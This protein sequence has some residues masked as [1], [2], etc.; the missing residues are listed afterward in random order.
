ML[1][2]VVRWSALICH[3]HLSLLL[4]LLLGM[5]V[6]TTK[7]I[8]G[9]LA[10]EI[11]R[12]R[13]VLSCPR[14]GTLVINIDHFPVHIGLLLLLLRMVFVLRL[15]RILLL[16]LMQMLIMLMLLLVVRMSMLLLL[17]TSPMLFPLPRLLHLQ[18][19]KM[20]LLP[21][22]Q[23]PHRQIICFPN[24]HI[25]LQLAS[26]VIGMKDARVRVRG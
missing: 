9:F 7:S 23:N 16:S 18:L 22:L 21:R 6:V 1:L 13:R 26:A 8:E 11:D 12:T 15:D 5:M 25:R 24:I 2:Q 20:S 19:L 17:K 10:Q 14:N 3:G 4:L